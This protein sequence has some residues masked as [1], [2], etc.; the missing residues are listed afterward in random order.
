MLTI[1]FRKKLDNSG[2]ITIFIKAASRL[3]DPDGQ[4][5]GES[6][7]FNSS[8]CPYMGLLTGNRI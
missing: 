4:L 1:I 6:N 8:C 2:F 5:K 7:E 3:V